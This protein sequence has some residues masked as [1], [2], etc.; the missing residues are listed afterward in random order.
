MCDWSR[1]VFVR[2]FE[3]PALQ[4]KP[5]V[6]TFNL[7][8]L[9][10]HGTHKLSKDNVYASFA[11]CVKKNADP[12]RHFPTSFARHDIGFKSYANGFGLLL[13]PTLSPKC[14]YPFDA[15]T[16]SDLKKC[17]MNAYD[18]TFTPRRVD[19]ARKLCTKS[20]K[21]HDIIGSQAHSFG[22][23]GA[24]MSLALRY[25]REYNWA[26]HTSCT[27]LNNVNQFSLRWTVDDVIGVFYVR[28]EDRRFA[29][30]AQRQLPRKVPLCLLRPSV[31]GRRAREPPITRSWLM[32]P[33][34]LARS[35]Q[36]RN[37]EPVSEADAPRGGG[38]REGKKNKKK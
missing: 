34:M 18:P 5:W 19:H 20:T 36:S 14:S 22:C 35:T 2:V 3:C 38:A 23:C 21:Q 24:N 15:W 11:A 28:A 25:Q 12:R 33:R 32:T 6:P 1:G 4:P 31:K 10:L 13:S 37:T 30:Y 7:T 29:E 8:H 16:F 26:E 17:K 27:R 9:T